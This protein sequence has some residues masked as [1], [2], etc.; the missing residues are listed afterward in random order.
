MLRTAQ[1]A[2]SFVY[3]RMMTVLQRFYWD[4]AIRI[5]AMAAVIVPIPK[6]QNTKAAQLKGNR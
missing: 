4:C 3:N 5:A 1:V 2:I 6:Y